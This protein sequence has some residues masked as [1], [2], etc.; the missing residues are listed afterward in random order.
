MSYSY[1]NSKY[2]SHT[3]DDEQTKTNT[4]EYVLY[5]SITLSTK[6][7]VWKS[8]FKFNSQIPVSLSELS[9]VDIWKDI[10]SYLK[11]LS[12]QCGSEMS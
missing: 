10:K 4:A 1:I 11:F 8:V 2:K 6:T 7:I 5:D 9:Q 12:R 3:R